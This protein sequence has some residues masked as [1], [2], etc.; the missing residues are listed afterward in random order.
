ISDKVIQSES[1]VT[2]METLRGW[3]CRTRICYFGA[4]EDGRRL[5]AFVFSPQALQLAGDDAAPAGGEVMHARSE[6]AAALSR[7]SKAE[8]RVLAMIGDGLSTQEMADRTGR[9]IKTI[10]GHRFAIGR[11]LE[12]TNRVEL[13]R[14]A[15]RAGL[16][17]LE[18]R[19]EGAPKLSGG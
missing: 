2:L 9:S 19:L 10:E 12:A 18:Q 4:G 8:I 16:S 5:A 17:S 15:I 6:D 11:K 1:P 7:L 3:R 13:A 14:I